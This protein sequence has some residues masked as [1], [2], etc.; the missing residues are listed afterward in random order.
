[1]DVLGEFVLVLLLSTE[2]KGDENAL[3]DLLGGGDNLLT[4]VEDNVGYGRA[5]Q[6]C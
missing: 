2:A 3:P 6:S 4:M 5:V 1:V